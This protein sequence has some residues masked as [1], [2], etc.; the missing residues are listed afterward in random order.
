MGGDSDDDGD[1][2]GDGDG[3]GGDD[4]HGDDVKRDGRPVLRV[5]NRS[6]VQEL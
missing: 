3:E 5:G 1:G 6:R 4:D 2:D